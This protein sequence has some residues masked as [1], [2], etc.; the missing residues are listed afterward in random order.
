[1]KDRV[2]LVFLLLGLF[3]LGLLVG[4]TMP[5]HARADTL[6]LETNVDKDLVTILNQLSSQVTTL[7]AGQSTLAVALDGMA[8]AMDGDSGVNLT[9]Y[10]S[11]FG[12]PCGTVAT[13]ISAL[14]V[15]HTAR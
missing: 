15:T 14:A 11:T 6:V 10:D 4:R 5:P 2:Q 1:M 12:N 3:M 8:A 7:K 9:T 13:T